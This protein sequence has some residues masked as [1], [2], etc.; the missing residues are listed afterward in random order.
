MLGFGQCVLTGNVEFVKANIMEKHIDAAEVVG[1]DIDLLP[2]I[3]PLYAVLAQHLPGL[4][5][6]G[7][8]A[9]GRVIDLIN[10]R[11]AH[12]PQTGQQLRHIRGREKFAAALSSVGGIHRHQKFVGIS[13]GVDAVAV[14]SAQVH[15]GNAVEQF[16]QLFIALGDSGPQ[17]V[18]VHIKIIKEAGKALF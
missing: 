13:K 17:F 3:A 9:A 15:S 7:A 8:G 4:Q 1:S 18:A 10:L 2:I 12:G 6:K 5:K 16:H 14:D 11:F